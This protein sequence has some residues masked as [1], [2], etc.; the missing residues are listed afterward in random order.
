MFVL[1]ALSSISIAILQASPNVDIEPTIGIAG[2]AISAFV[3]TLIVGVIMIA[4]APEF[5]ERRMGEVLENPVGS[6]A[7]GIVALL[8]LFVLIVVLVITIIGILIAIPL[9]IVAWVVWAVGAVIAYLAVA[10]RLIGRA[11]GWL[12]PLFLAA[13]ING[14]LTVTGIGGLISLCVGAAGFGAV[15]RSQLG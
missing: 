5:T 3:T 9:A 10:D 2:G 7:Y 8:A 6:F 12:K 13:G 15:L 14:L 4:V 1:Q 11:D